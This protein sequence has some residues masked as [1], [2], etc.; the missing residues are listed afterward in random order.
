MPTKNRAG[1][2]Q[3]LD[4]Q[5][6]SATAS[7]T[8]Y[9]STTLI[10]TAGTVRTT[11]SRTAGITFP[12]RRRREHL[13]FPLP[14][15]RQP[16]L[17]LITGFDPA[18]DV[19]DLSHIDA[20]LTA[21]GLQS[22]T[23][24]GT[25]AFTSRRRAGELSVRSDPQLTT[26]QATLAGDITPDLADRDRRPCHA[27][28]RQFRPDSRPIDGSPRRTARP[29]RSRPSVQAM[30]GST[31]IRTLRAEPIRLTPASDATTGRGG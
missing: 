23:F 1:L 26:V 18:K 28:R 17:R 7:T 8:L 21:A 16:L 14:Y 4:N 27:H 19:I 22:F 12:R 11:S 15:R 25:N 2:D 29:S 6:S 30:R 24:I 13:H 20:D 5:R 9:G 3:R 10:C 31:S